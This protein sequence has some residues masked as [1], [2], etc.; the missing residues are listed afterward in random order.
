VF[1]V[2]PAGV[3]NV[4]SNL[5]GTDAALNKGGPGFLVLTGTTNQVGFG[6]VR[7]VRITGGLLRAVIQGPTANFG[8]TNNTLE[9]RGGVFEVDSQGGSSS[10]T[11]DLG[12]SS[13]RANWG[14]TNTNQGSGGFSAV[15]GTLTVNLGGAT[16]VMNW[17][18]TSSGS[19]VRDG[20]A[21]LF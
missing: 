16:A 11:R 2:D 7:D 21:L 9:F 19:F 8:T 6:A 10:F 1:V 17:G 20:A 4:S 18:D 3:L 15:N 14:R 5:A 13:G 12:T